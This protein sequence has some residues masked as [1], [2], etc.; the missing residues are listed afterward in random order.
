MG[1]PKRLR[2]I[3][4]ESSGIL[5]PDFNKTEIITAIGPNFGPI[6]PPIEGPMQFAAGKKLPVPIIGII[7]NFKATAFKMAN[8]EVIIPLVNHFPFFIIIFFLQ[9][10]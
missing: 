1:K 2:K 5:K 7:L 3:K 9:F 4:K 8:I 10:F 6:I